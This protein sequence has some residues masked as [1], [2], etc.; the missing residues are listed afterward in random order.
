M[1]VSPGLLKKIAAEIR[2]AGL[3]R[4][5]QTIVLAALENNI[6][7]QVIRPR[8]IKDATGLSKST[9]ERLEKAGEFPQRRQLSPYGAAT[10][11]MWR[12]DILPWLESRERGFGS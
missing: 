5:T 10:G 2:L 12:E 4:Q 6:P 9:I 8:D 1:S 11:W 7:D 3:P